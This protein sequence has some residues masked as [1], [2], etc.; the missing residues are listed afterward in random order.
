MEEKEE[1]CVLASYSFLNH[2]DTE[3]YTSITNAAQLLLSL[4]GFQRLYIDSRRANHLR[5]AV[6][7]SS[8]LHGTD[9]DLKATA[10]NG[11][12]RNVPSKGLK[13][14]YLKMIDCTYMAIS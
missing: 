13:V 5:P 12:A 7:F 1:E 11:R 14:Y 8:I 10:R 6:F 9:I 3:H 2:D 4:F